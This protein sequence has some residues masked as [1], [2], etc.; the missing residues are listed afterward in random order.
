MRVLILSSDTGEGHNSAAKATKEALENRGCECSIV[1]TMS[2]RGSRQKRLVSNSYNKLVRKAPAAFGAVYKAGDLYSSTGIPSPVYFANTLY[3]KSLA[4][5]VKENGYDA[6]VCTHLFAME[7]L[8]YLKKKNEIDFPCF[9]VLTDYTCI[10]FL[11]ETRLDEYFVP[12][13]AVRK[14]CI[15]KG[16]DEKKLFAT[17]IPVSGRFK[18]RLSRD[19]ARDY[20]AIPKDIPVFLI[21]TGGVGSGNAAAICDRLLETEKTDF[22]AYVFVGRN[23]DLKEALEKRYHENRQ[24]RIVAFT[25]DINIYMNA[26]DVLISKAG[27]ITSTEAAVAGVPLVHTMMIPGCETKNAEL[28]EACGMSFKADDPKTAVSL[29]DELVNNKETAERMRE[30]QHR[31]INENAADDIAERVM[32]YGK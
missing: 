30:T 27:G 23:N 5:Y 15:E 2:F 3:A 6:V 11:K 7:A 17:G 20:L 22:L 12:S 18:R 24:I 9:S 4:N 14:E 1:D 31:I 10:P 26:A 16:M 28:F 21:M 19:E 13:E 32:S 29:A 25:E 8:T